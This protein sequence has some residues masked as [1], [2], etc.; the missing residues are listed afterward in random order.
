MSF[1]WGSGRKDDPLASCYLHQLGET[2]GKLLAEF[3]AR[4]PALLIQ[5]REKSEEARTKVALTIWGVHLDSCSDACDIVLLKFLRAEELNIDKAAGR[6]VET[7]VFRSDCHIDEVA[8]SELPS[9]FQ[10]HDTVRGKDVDG[11][12]LMI[13][14]FGGMDLPKVFGD[15]EAFVRYRAFLMEQ[16]MSQLSWQK[17]EPED[18]CQVHDYS[19]VPLIFHSSEVKGSVTAVTK[20]FS[21]HYPETKGKTIFVNFPSAFA[22]LFKAFSVF[23]PERTRKKFLILGEKDHEILFEHIKPEMVPEVLGGMQKQPP[24]ILDSI[25]CTV[26]HV[27]ARASEKALL[28]STEPG[29]AGRLCWELRVCAVD[30]TYEVSFCPTGGTARSIAGPASL[31]ASQGIASGEFEATEAGSLEVSFKNDGAWFKSRLCACRGGAFP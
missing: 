3:R 15:V 4:L 2:E 20:V 29:R 13:S 12:P 25:T 22:S 8:G 28:C 19:G 6:F 26:V 11:R 30:I 21:K 18:L 16:A 9:H 7:L 31:Q 10:G 1:L 27:A 23:I 5:V 14:R 24:S 17:G